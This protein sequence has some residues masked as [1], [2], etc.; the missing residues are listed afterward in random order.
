MKM[1][2]R[3]EAM[4]AHTSR[5]EKDVSDSIFPKAKKNDHLDN[6]IAKG[7]KE[8]PRTHVKVSEQDY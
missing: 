2:T 7:P 5:W 3:K 6:W 4:N 8:W 1:D